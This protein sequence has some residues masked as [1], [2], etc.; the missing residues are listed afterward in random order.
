MHD[1][2]PLE[3]SRF[4]KEGINLYLERIRDERSVD[5]EELDKFLEASLEEIKYLESKL[6]TSEDK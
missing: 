3:T 5:L 6:T 1:Q 2:T 4:L